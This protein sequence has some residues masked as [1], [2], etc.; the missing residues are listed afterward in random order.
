[1]RTQIMYQTLY[2]LSQYTICVNTLSQSTICKHTLSE[3]TIYVHTLY[4]CTIY[5]HTL[6]QCNICVHTLSESTICTPYFCT[7]YLCTCTISESIYSVILHWKCFSSVLW[8]N[9]VSYVLYT[10]YRFRWRWPS[11]F[12]SRLQPTPLPFH[13]LSSPP[14]ARCGGSMTK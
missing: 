4:Q 12:L 8:S 11:S 13:S 7:R 6:Y 2:A 14:W 9:H 1:M 5:V 3:C 10:D